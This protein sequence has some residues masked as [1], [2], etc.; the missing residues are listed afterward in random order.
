MSPTALLA[1][2]TTGLLAGA[3]LALGIVFVLRR[4]RN[5]TQDAAATRLGELLAPLRT[6]LER[7]DQ[8]LASFDRDRATQFGALATRLDL[9]AAASESV[10]DQTQQLA[11][12]LRTPNVRGRWG[13]VQLRRVVELAGM[14]EHCDF[15]TQVASHGEDGDGD[16][17]RMR[18]DMVVRLPGGRSVIVD[19]KAPLLAYLDA[20]SCT[21]ERERARLLRAHAGHV[22]MH[23]EALSRKAYWEQLGPGAT[24]EFVVL[25]L[26]GEAFFSAAL[27]HDAALLDESAA[28][29]VILATPTTLIA[30]LRAVSFGWREARMADSARE[31]STLGATLYDRLSTLGGHMS[32]VGGALDR[33]VTSYNRAIGS[34]EGRVLV[35]ARRFRDLGAAGD[36]AEIEPLSP[37]GTRARGVQAPELVVSTPLE[38]IEPGVH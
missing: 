17:R 38:Q 20:T 4:D 29:G 14:E 9:V 28:R 36:R 2:F 7:Y 24:P 27:E 22:R 13:E 16:A 21:D 8:R 5:E 34:L 10:R 25:F 37:V 23:V 30:L 35:S 15:E 26:P 1:V 18:P 32:E 11:S 6:E 3:V 19:A 12:A 33:A 31:I